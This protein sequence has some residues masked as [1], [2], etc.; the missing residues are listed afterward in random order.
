M[1][2]LMPITLRVVE[3]TKKPFPYFLAEQFVP[4]SLENELL[5]WL[6]DGAPWRLVET[7]FYQQYEFN[8]FEADMPASL[9]WLVSPE[10]LAHLREL[11]ETTLGCRLTDKTELVAHKLLAG[12]RIGIHNDYL[13][14]QETHRLTVQLNQGLNDED[15]GFFML[16][17]SFDASDIHKV[18]RPLS[19]SAVGFE[20]SQDSHHAV[21]RMHGGERYTLVYSF[22]AHRSAH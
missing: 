2:E 13:E 14:G 4:F 9:A 1:P 17:N 8:L 21:S 12:Q 7:D 19:G 3:Q 18:L 10:C 16:F 11:I 5:A 22:Y 6:K 20:I 15:G